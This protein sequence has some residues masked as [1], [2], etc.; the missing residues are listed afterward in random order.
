M[1]K[2]IYVCDNDGK[3]IGIKPHLSLSLNGGQS[4]VAI[5]PNTPIP[6]GNTPTY[7]RV[8]SIGANQL[9][10]CS[11]KCAGEYLERQLVK[12]KEF[13]KGKPKSGK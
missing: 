10:F 2:N 12:A 6:G 1:K 9:Q 4:G 8:N 5:P 11:G 7:W 3:P 13:L